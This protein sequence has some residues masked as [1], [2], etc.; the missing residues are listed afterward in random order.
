MT[1][2][3]NCFL[4]TSRFCFSRLCHLYVPRKN[5]M[6]KLE[7]VFPVFNVSRQDHSLPVFIVHPLRLAHNQEFQFLFAK[8]TVRCYFFCFFHHSTASCRDNNIF[9]QLK[10]SALLLM[11]SD[12]CLCFLRNKSLCVASSSLV[13]RLPGYCQKKSIRP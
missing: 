4:R 12:A 11:I 1:R 3:R 6:Q 8:S 13:V 9:H 10:H 2:E 5:L 7:E